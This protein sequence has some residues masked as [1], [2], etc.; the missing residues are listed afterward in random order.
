MSAL[1]LPYKKNEAHYK[2]VEGEA[3]AS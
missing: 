3:T 1:Q 2:E